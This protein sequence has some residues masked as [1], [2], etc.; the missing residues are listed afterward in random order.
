MVD[1]P[2]FGDGVDNTGCWEPIIQYVDQQFNMFL[3]AETQV[4]TNISTIS[5]YLL[6]LPQV[7]RVRVPDTRVHACL[8]FLAPSGHGLR[9]S[10]LC[11]IID[12]VVLTFRA[13]EP[14]VILTSKSMIVQRNKFV[15]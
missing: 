4:S 14:K 15:V 11:R 10:E 8:Y 5:T 2:G 3:E 9:R 7:V 6:Y 1:T 13:I 12:I